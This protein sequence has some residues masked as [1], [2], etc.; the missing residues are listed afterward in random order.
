MSLAVREIM[1]QAR[2]LVGGAVF[3]RV[4][5]AIALVFV[6]RLYTPSELG[7]L[8]IASSFV[9]ILGPILTLRYANAIPLSRSNISAAA[10]AWLSLICASIL[11]LFVALVFFSFPEIWPAAIR[12]SERSEFAAVVLIFVGVYVVNDLLTNVMIRIG[13]LRGI[14]IAS[15]VQTSAGDAVKIGFGLAAA[16]GLYLIVAAILG[17]VC[18]IIYLLRSKAERGRQRARCPSLIR[19]RRVALA[20][21][22]F[23]VLRM[24]SNLLMSFAA[25]FPILYISSRYELNDAGQFALAFSLIA[26][27][28]AILARTLSAAHYSSIARLGR[29]L[30]S[31]VLSISRGLVV[32]LAFLTAPLSIALLISGPFLFSFVFGDEW[33]RAGHFASALAPVLFSQVLYTSCANITNV[34]GTQKLN[35]IIN[36]Q[37]L[38]LTV[39][40]FGYSYFAGIEVL[41]AVQIYSCVLALHYLASTYRILSGKVS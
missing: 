32:R 13:N 39:S 22:A 33:L 17:Y 35:L 6:A 20:Y 26:L 11:L 18:S 28:V 27:P 10:L 36:A 37:R 34:L 8:A 7:M 3:S 38:V 21:R 1:V 41:A 25:Q 4:I 14:G 24:P 23:P 2:P 31:E 5:A 16:S 19:M 9:L 15:V 40:A 12:E 29:K 30:H